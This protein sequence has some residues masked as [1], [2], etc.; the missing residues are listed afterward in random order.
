M[1]SEKIRYFFSFFSYNLG[2]LHIVYTKAIVVN[3]IYNV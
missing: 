1:D 2:C 3:M